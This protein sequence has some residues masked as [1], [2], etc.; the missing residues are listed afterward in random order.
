MGGKATTE[1]ELVLPEYPSV[2]QFNECNTIYSK[3]KQPFRE[4]QCM[5]ICKSL[6]D[7]IVSA[8]PYST[9]IKLLHTIKAIYQDFNGDKSDLEN[10][11]AAI[12]SASRFPETLNKEYLEP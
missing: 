11:N 5:N 9:N 8:K 10:I 12:Y 2:S 6:T 7:I 4:D 3:T 1:P